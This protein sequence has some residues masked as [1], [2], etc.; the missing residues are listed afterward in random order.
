MLSSFE[1]W[2]NADFSGFSARMVVLRPTIETWAVPLLWMMGW[3][4]LAPQGLASQKPIAIA[5]H[6]GAGTILKKNMTPEKEQAYIDHLNKSLAIGYEVLEKG[7]TSLD[8][9]VATIVFMEDSPLFNA[10]KGAVFTNKG[11]HELDA[12]IM[13]GADLS[14]GCV[15]GVSRIKNPILLARAVLDHSPHVLLSGEGAEQFA[16]DRGLKMVDPEYFRTERRWK[17]LQEALDKE[18]RSQPA[19]ASSKHGTVGVVALDRHGNLAA[20][21]STG[22]LTNKKFGRIGDSPLIGAGTYATNQGCAVSAT[23]QGEYFIRA[24]VARDISALVE[25]TGM[26]VQ[27]AADKVIK[28]KLDSIG[29]TGGVIVLDRSGNVAFSFN[30]EG[31]YRGY[32]R[33][34]ADPVVAIYR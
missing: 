32:R 6:G 10:G 7:G 15:A 29:G 17:E 11:T 16:R 13:N 1:W 4:F 22:G 31:M 18:R 21:T 9:V 2:P 24:T 12:S 8:A 19:P 28:T 23:G 34:G 27:R 30:T 25:M 20:G 33:S 5:I 14:A 26:D 3:F